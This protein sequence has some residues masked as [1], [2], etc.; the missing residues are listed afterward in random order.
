M[1]RRPPRSTL[2]PYTTLF[3]SMPWWDEAE[4]QEVDRWLQRQGAA[5]ARSALERRVEAMLGDG[6]RVWGLSSG[7]AAIQ[8]ALQ[9][10]RLPGDSEVLI[11]SFLCSSVAVAV[12]Q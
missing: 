5:G 7:R 3:R 12:I 1:I 4:W 8:V 10:F 11:P 9:A 2:F 6:W